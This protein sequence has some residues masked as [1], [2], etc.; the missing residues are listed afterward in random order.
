[1]RAAGRL[2]AARGTATPTADGH[3]SVPFSFFFSPPPSFRPFPQNS[4]LLPSSLSF[5]YCGGGWNRAWGR[6]GEREDVGAG[7]RSSPAP[8][9]GR[10]GAATT[11]ASPP[12]PTP[13]ARGTNSATLRAL[14]SF[15][16]ERGVQ[17]KDSWGE[18]APGAALHPFLPGPDSLCAVGSLPWP[19]AGGGCSS[20][21]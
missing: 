21:F 12:A 7:Q 3:V 17:S 8:G 5:S 11:P 18:R 2:G 14:P 16:S 6:G 20:E 1:M 10:G 13:A 15:S 9:E 4:T 19:Q